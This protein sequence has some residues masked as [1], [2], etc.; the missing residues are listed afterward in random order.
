MIVRLLIGALGFGGHR[1]A[2]FPTGSCP[3]TANPFVTTLNGMI[4]GLLIAVSL[5]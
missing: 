5:R 3:L 4:I 1:L 2:G